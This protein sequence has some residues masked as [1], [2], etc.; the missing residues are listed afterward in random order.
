MPI[1][2]LFIA[3]FCAG[4]HTFLAIGVGVVSATGYGHD[5]LLLHDPVAILWVGGIAVFLFYFFSIGIIFEGFHFMYRKLPGTKYFYEINVLFGVV[6]I[7][8]LWR[9][10]VHHSCEEIVLQLFWAL[11]SLYIFWYLITRYQYYKNEVT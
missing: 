6:W 4:I 2:L 9:V 10:Y 5:I 7:L 11:S 3:V 8:L 1:V